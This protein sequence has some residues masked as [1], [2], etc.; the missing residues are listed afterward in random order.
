MR[1]RIRHHG[2][3]SLVIAGL[4][5]AA[6]L[7]ARTTVPDPVP[8]FAEFGTKGLRAVKVVQMTDGHQVSLSEQIE[9]NRDIRNDLKE[10]EAALQN[11]DKTL[12]EQEKR[13]DRLETEQLR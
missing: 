12:N 11:A 2:F 8:A 1:H 3:S 4:A 6:Y 10:T 7:A 5:A 9:F 13:L